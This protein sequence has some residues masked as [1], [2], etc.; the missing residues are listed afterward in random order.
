MTETQREALPKPPDFWDTILKPAAKS[1][2]KEIGLAEL[3]DFGNHT[4]KLI[5]NDDFRA[6]VSSIRDKGIKEPLIVR[7]HPTVAG[8][9]EI[10]AGHRRRL[11]AKEAGLAHVPCIVEPLSDADAIILM[12]ES[13][14]QR[15]GWLPSEKANTYKAHLDATTELFNIR[16]GRPAGNSPTGSANLRA[17]DLAA[18]RFGV[19]GDQLRMY[20][21]LTE[22][23]PE[24][25]DL[26]D[27]HRIPVKAGYQLAFISNDAQQ[28]ILTVMQRSPKLRINEASA[29]LIREVYEASGNLTKED[30]ENVFSLRQT[31]EEG[32]EAIQK[33]VRFTLPD[34]F[35]GRLKL[36]KDDPE[37]LERIEAVIWKYLGEVERSRT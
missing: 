25:L 37:L 4:F 31:H 1:N 17:D 11:A 7:P 10:I 26:V 34:V 13:N 22:L 35:D 30:V 5:D 14:I 8:E 24:L 18:E 2:I 21:K 33:N 16:A 28:P 9:Y 6:L 20:I 23:L 29:K 12:A 19:S 15:P 27:E 3:H 32:T 36:H